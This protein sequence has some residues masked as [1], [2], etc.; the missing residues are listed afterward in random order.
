MCHKLTVYYN[1]KTLLF[2]NT[3]ECQYIGYFTERY[4]LSFF[5]KYFQITEESEPVL[6]VPSWE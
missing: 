6:K 1:E 3:F 2:F 5:A 4:T